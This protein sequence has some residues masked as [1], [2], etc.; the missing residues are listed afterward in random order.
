MEIR[1]I[2]VSAWQGKI[3]WGTVAAYGMDFVLLRITEAGNVIDSC[4]ER[5]FSECRKHNIPVGVYKYS[6]AMTIAE[7]QN[8]A[9][10]VVSVL[11]GRKLQF[12]VWLDLE[13]NKQ[14]SLGA[15]SIHK[16]AD[17][18]RE[19]VEAAGY[20]FGI[21]CNVDWYMNVICSH[22]RKHDFWIA[23]YPAADNGILQERLRPDFGVGWQY[24]SK[25][26]IPGINGTVDRNIFYK[27]YKDGEKKGDTEVA[28]TK[29]QIIQ[30]VRNDAVDFAVK[31]ANDNSHGY[32][33]TVRSL[34]NITNPKSF[35]CSSLALT[36][37]YYAF[38]K[39]GLTAQANYLKANCSYT[40]NMLKMQNA[41]FEIVA[42]NQTAHA[43]MTK[44][45]L[46][47]NTAHHVAMAIDRNRIIHARSSEG[48][49]DTKDNSG[50]EI[51]VQNWYLY[52]HG[53]THRLRFTGK[54]IDFTELTGTATTTPASTPTTTKG[55]K[56]MFEPKTVKNGSTGTS[57]LLLQE[58]LV[59]RGFKGKDGKEL[60]LDRE[61]GTNTIYALNQ[62]KK[63]RKMKQNG[64]CDAAVWKD[65]IAI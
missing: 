45:D 7:I 14:R 25:A 31:I 22:L 12:P 21:Y 15:E 10:K 6:Y 24:S 65:L 18:F 43:Q 61:A 5:N 20:K 11:N 47:L 30:N 63:S 13:H 2:D 52:S 41:G 34:Y 9:R 26:K 50:N 64:I 55:D 33:Q 8:E 54:G 29:E 19:I 16:M 58:I 40:G 4:F 39:N 37:Y 62:Y 28:K 3:D 56:Y 59:A 32:S 60:T 48:T 57:V 36:A 42:R 38:L 27:D 51:R 53:W 1:G 46:E 23:R 44:G 17:A 35:D 49:S